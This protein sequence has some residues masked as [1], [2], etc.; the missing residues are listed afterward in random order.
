[1]TAAASKRAS[2]SFAVSG[3][4]PKKAKGSP[5]PSSSFPKRNS[6]KKLGGKGNVIYNTRVAESSSS[7]TIA[8]S[9]CML[10]VAE[11]MNVLRFLIDYHPGYEGMSVPEECPL[12][13]KQ[14]P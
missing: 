11:F 5:G 9:K 10:D 12:G 6:P 13:S 4:S 2:S 3:R 14:P 1:M 8:R 7:L